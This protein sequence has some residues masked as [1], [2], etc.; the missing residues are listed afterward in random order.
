MEATKN[1]KVKKTKGKSVLSKEDDKI[2]IVSK[3]YDVDTG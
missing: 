3:R 2:Y 1:Y